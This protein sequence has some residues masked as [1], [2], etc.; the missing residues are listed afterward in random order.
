MK[1]VVFFCPNQQVGDDGHT[2]PAA[3][4]YNDMGGVI[5][6]SQHLDL[7][8]EANKPIIESIKV[9]VRSILERI[10]KA[11]FEVKTE[12]FSVVTLKTFAYQCARKGALV[13]EF[14]TETG[15]YIPLYGPALVYTMM[16]GQLSD[17]AGWYRIVW[18]DF[19]F[20]PRK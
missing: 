18:G 11:G 15:K 10:K 1:L 16:P 2:Y 19:E 14:N 13:F 7:K 5:A 20:A 8:D 4:W 6:L 9:A 17:P 3:S 12:E